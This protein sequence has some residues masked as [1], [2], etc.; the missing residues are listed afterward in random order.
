MNIIATINAA[1]D[2]GEFNEIVGLIVIPAMS[3]A[4]EADVTRLR[5]VM[6]NKAATLLNK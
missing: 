4:N 5:E 3:E 6:T 2:C 1:T